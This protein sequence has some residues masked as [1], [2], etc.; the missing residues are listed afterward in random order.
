MVKYTSRNREGDNLDFKTLST[1]C[2]SKKGAMEDYPFGH[3]VLVIKMASKMFALISERN[4]QLNISLKCDPL[5]AEH[6]R[7]QYPAITA[8][9]HLNKSHWNTIVID[10][11]L[12]ES[13]LNKMIDHSYDL[14]FK[15]LKKSDKDAIL[16][17]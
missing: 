11:S 14:V 16:Q 9:Y 5:L 2:L 17:H 7:Q 8:G 12:S 4:N 6:L 1:Y 15:G 10:G 13:H 3:N